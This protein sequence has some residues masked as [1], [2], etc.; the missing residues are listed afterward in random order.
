MPVFQLTE[1]IQFPPT[2]LAEDSGLLAVGGDL[3]PARLLLAYKNGI[4]PWFSAGDPLLWWFT[5]PRLVIFPDEFHIP[6]RVL[7]YHRKS[8]LTITRDTAFE[9]VIHQCAVIRTESGEETWI[10]DT[11]TEAYSKLHSLG[12]AHSVE[13]WQDDILVGGLYGIALGKVFFGESMF[14]RIRSG[15]QFALIALVEFLKKENFQMIDCQMTTN[16]LL[17][18]GARE[19][20]GSEFQSLLKLNI[21]D[22]SPQDNWYSDEKN[23]K[24][25]LRPLRQEEKT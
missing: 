18:F 13:C 15:S 7:R 14:S 2:H 17:R 20:D 8:N 6:K 23:T 24:Q 12:F 10:V 9:E 22:I 21:G 5:S 25:N 16:H 4:F 3:S 1:D 19:I 11:M